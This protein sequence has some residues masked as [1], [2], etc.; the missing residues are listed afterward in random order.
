MASRIYL[1]TGAFGHVGSQIVQLLLRAGERVRALKYPGED[2]SLL[3][4]TDAEVFAGDVRDKD[5]LRPFFHVPEGLKAQVIH[6]AGIVS[7]AAR[8]DENLRRV[9]VDG[10]RN[11]VELCRETNV[12]RLLYISSVHALPEKP[13][14]EAVREINAFDPD[15]VTGAYAKTKAEASQIVLD[16]AKEG[17]DA[18]M[19][20]PSGIIG[21]GDNGNNHANQVF[22]DFLYGRLPAI[23]RGGYDFVDVRDVA[24]GCL[25]ALDAGRP[26]N[27]YIL[28]N[29][30]Y[31]IR[32]LI[33]MLQRITGQKRRVVALPLWFVSA[34]APLAENI[35]RLRRQKP[36]FTRYSLYTLNTNDC[37]SSE[38]ARTELGYT[39]R[40]MEETMR[41]IVLW[42][43]MKNGPPKQKE[44]RR[45]R[46]PAHA[47]GR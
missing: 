2:D 45:K 38:K 24:Q 23:I 40:P 12:Q 32:Q 29:A 16:A 14:G 41:D 22:K 33:G 26:G 44:P 20:H 37:F 8:V 30:H 39:V 36:L 43:R 21:P 4:G 46:V 47:K 5:S 42:E 25:L 34:F 19:V 28:S 27:G 17:L 3:Q 10:T 1:V 35:D 18:L 15:W 7:I 6:A 11:V 13:R 31:D 9:N